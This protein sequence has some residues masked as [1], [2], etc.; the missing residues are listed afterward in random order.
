MLL[1]SS[2]IPLI[3]R[4][5]LLMDNPTIG[6]ISVVTVT[7]TQQSGKRPATNTVKTA[8]AINEISHVSEQAGSSLPYKSLHIVNYSPRKQSLCFGGRQ[9]IGLQSPSIHCHPFIKFISALWCALMHF[10]R[11]VKP[12]IHLSPSRSQGNDSGWCTA[13]RLFQLPGLNSSFPTST[14]FLFPPHFLEAVT[15]KMTWG[16]TMSGWNNIK[17]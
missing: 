12:Q 11:C 2:H 7:N 4:I 15:F 5:F 14:H 6:T 17:P 10:P 8:S 13:C 9:K 16:M 3:C 1:L